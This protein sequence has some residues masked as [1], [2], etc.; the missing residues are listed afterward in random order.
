MRAIGDL[1]S[2]MLASRL[3]TDLRNQ[4]DSAAESA[5]TGLAADK[6][7]HLGGATLAI[8]LLER[9]SSLL[10]QHQRGISEAAVL[11]GA[12]QAT[13]ERIQEQSVDLANDL[14][15]V[16]QL[17]NSSQIQALSLDASRVFVDTVN[18][19]NSSIA[20][21]YLFSGSATQ[22]KPLPDGA[23]FLDMIR[24]DLAGAS[25]AADV[26]AGVDAWFDALSGSFDAVY[27]G[28]TDGF[29]TL[30]LSSET[31]AVFA[32]RADGETP[33]G[34]LRA[35][36][37]TALAESAG[38]SLPEQSQILE[39]GRAD[40]LQGDQWLTEERASLGLTEARIADAASATEADITRIELDR[41]SLIGVDQFEAA[42]EFEAAQQQLDVFYRIAARQSRTSLAEYLR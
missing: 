19:L 41:L 1:A 13:L 29:M 39:A 38:L 6:A 31:T 5:T 26:L 36:A 2:Y 17:Q 28:S 40:L 37:K 4:A 12:S 18:A 25:S 7:R 21:R 32:L 16:P 15:I 24:T 42:A 30:P 34:V 20:G 10:V 33:R 9:K 14:A 11:A 35:L 3:Q 27:Q 8:T 22:T 23:V